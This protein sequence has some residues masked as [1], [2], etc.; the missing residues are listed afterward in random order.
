MGGNVLGPLLEETMELALY[1]VYVCLC[2][3]VCW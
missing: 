1:E 3:C 2:V